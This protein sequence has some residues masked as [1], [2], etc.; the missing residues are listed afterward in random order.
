VT[1]IV[2]D[3][4]RVRALIDTLQDRQE[5]VRGRA[6]EQRERLDLLADLPGMLPVA[7]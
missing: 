7:A 5:T 6:E 1:D 3:A 4:Q 2:E